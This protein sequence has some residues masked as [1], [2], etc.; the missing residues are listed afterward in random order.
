LIISLKGKW[1]V[2]D[3]EGKYTF[4]GNVP[5]TVQGDL[6]LQNLVPHPYVGLNE[7]YMRDLE[8][9]SWTYIKEFELGDLPTEE[10][11]EL[12]FEGVDTLS[13]IYLNGRYLGNTEDMFLEYRFDIKDILKKG[14]NVLKVKIKSPVKEPKTL[15]RVYGKI[16]AS[17]ESMRPYIRKAQY[18][19]G[20]DWGARLVASGIWRPVYIESYNKAR[21][22]GC[23]AY[24]EKMCDRNGT[25]RVSGYVLS[26][27]GV[28][29]PQN[30]R[31][32][33][34]LNDEITSE[35]PIES[36]G[37]EVQFEGAFALEN[38]R[39]WF[40]NGLGEQYLY[41][42]EFKLKYEGAEVYS[43]KKKIGL[44]T[45]KLIKEKDAEGESFI[46][47]V[48]GKHVFAKGA[49]WI[50][51][52]NI[53]TW[54]KPEDYKKLLYMARE[55]N[56]N[57]L[58]VWGGGVYEDK[59]FYTLCDELG[60]MIWQ[61][62]MFAFAEYPDHLEWFRKLSNKEVREIVKK[63]RYHASIALWCGNNENNWGFEEWPMMAHKVNGEHLGNKLYL[64]D[65]PMICAQ[66]DPSRPYWPSSPYG[67]DRAN[68]T[69]YG[70][71]HIWN[72]WSGWVD[73]KSYADENG[74]FISEFG[75]QA[76]PDS[77]TID[78]FA[79]KEEQEIFHPVILNH[80]KQVEGQERILRFI[81]SH[82][83]LITGFDTFVYLSQL[84]QAEAIKFGVE[85][86]RARKYRTA[87]TL[88]WQYNDSWPVFSWSAIDYFK[89]PKALYY[90]TKKFYANIL[91]IAYYEPSDQAVRVM[92]VNDH[93]EDKTVNILLEIWDTEERKIWEKKYEG[94]RILKDFVSTI[95]VVNIDEIPMKTLSDTVMYISVQCDEQEYENYFLFKDFKN[96]H[97]VD[98]ELSYVRE[99]DD[100]VFRCKR[101]AFGVHIVTEEECVPSDNFFDLVPSA[102][103]RIRCSSN[104]IKVKSLYDYLN[105]NFKKEGTS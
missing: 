23:T 49:N 84:N 78:F 99:G 10:D 58:R 88:Y 29:D 66:E 48:N 16:G 86:W 105:K 74:R 102:K 76:A 93:Y 103:K 82:F 26:A 17:E 27:A 19:Y 1:Q 51:A 11:V 90:Y 21:L 70:D 12:V 47:T 9:K 95:D 55:A 42:F 91:P 68:S 2:N 15:E 4:A 83:G 85:H 25:I 96:M 57:M 100:L 18:S 62:F 37:N 28:D 80:N 97:L 64:Q 92:V 32:E 71:C 81:N 77:K 8:N 104:K 52:D 94:I 40:P 7:E 34:R 46:F 36:V 33:V 50:P 3:D 53:L 101:P 56:M 89:R 67:G 5:G 30:Y 59:E 39:L 14:K 22:T 41:T 38:I 63:L 44:R 61:D 20:W 87:G 6:V 24:L 73:Y 54:I 13:D 60:I 98:P 79:K 75:F 65:F 43:E 45:V 69:E 35:F 31:V 72:V